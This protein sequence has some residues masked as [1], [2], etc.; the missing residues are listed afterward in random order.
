MAY[1]ETRETK[2]LILSFILNIYI[3]CETGLD[4]DVTDIY[5]S[6][7]RAGLW[8]GKWSVTLILPFKS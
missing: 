5:H 7:S 4:L 2:F 8:L 6:T 1:Y 3:L